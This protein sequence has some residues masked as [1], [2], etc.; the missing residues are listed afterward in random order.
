MQKIVVILLLKIFHPFRA[1]TL[2]GSVQTDAGVRS[3]VRTLWV[4]ANLQKN[5]FV[6]MDVY[7]GLFSFNCKWIEFN[8]NGV[9]TFCK[10]LRRALGLVEG[11]S[12]N[13]DSVIM[14]RKQ[15]V[16]FL[17][18][19]LLS[20]LPK[21][22]ALATYSMWSLHSRSIL[23]STMSCIDV[24]TLP[25]QNGMERIEIAYVTGLKWF[26]LGGSWYVMG[27]HKALELIALLERP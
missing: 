13:I 19:S 7:S 17:Y 23:L 16:G 26:P 11:A 1:L 22:G 27:K 21:N 4:F 6:I 5:D 20:A 10:R 3:E 14:L 18:R 15:R 9:E 24:M 25:P 8:A 12:L 2:L